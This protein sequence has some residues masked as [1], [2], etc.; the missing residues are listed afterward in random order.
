[1]KK[2]RVL[3]LFFVLAAVAV[4]AT[5]GL[6]AFLASS[7]LGW[8]GWVVDAFVGIGV[9][10][11]SVGCFSRNSP[12]FG[13]VLSGRRVEDPVLAL[14]F[15]DGPSPDTTP[16]I[17]DA[18]RAAG[19][20]ATFFVLGK[21]ATQHPELLARIVSEGHEVASH[22]WAHELLIF[23]RPSTFRRELERTA[24]LLVSHGV[25]QPRYFRAP[26]G[27]RGPLSSR[28][29]SRAG[30]QIVGWSAGVFDTALPG[31][32]VIVERS[33][34]ALHPGA[35]LLL[36]DADGNGNVTRS[37]TADALPAI[38]EAVHARGLRT[39]TVSE[40]ATIAPPRGLPW[41]RILMS[42]SVLLVLGFIVARIQ[43]IDWA[44]SVRVFAGLSPGL[45]TAA[46]LA[47]L[48]SIALKATVWQAALETLP[49]RPRIRYRHVVAAT[50]VG[51]L[52]N[53]ILPAR[54][55]EPA[56][57]IVLRRRI[58]RDSGEQVPFA[59]I[60]GTIIAESFVLG[61][62]LVALLVVM[63]F[64]IANVPSEFQAGVVALLGG[65][66][67][68]LVGVVSLHILG[69]VRDRRPA[70]GVVRDHG[71]WRLL[72]RLDHLVRQ[73]SHGQQ[74]FAHPPQIAL[75]MSA[76][77]GCWFANLIAIWFT[78]LAFGLR[79]HAFAAAVVVLAVSN[80]VGA[81]Q[82]T[83]GN[84][85]VFQ[86]ALVLALAHSFGVDSTLGLSFALG[87]Q[88]IE[89]GLGAALGLLFLAAEGLSFNSLRS[90]ARTAV[91]DASVV[92][93]D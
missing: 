36:H 90:S 77:L 21:H 7:G 78:A 33:V 50:L 22:G 32:E 34:R 55:G 49:T 1:M 59:T 75:S 4:G 63:T 35:I 91:L 71:V 41:S 86:I 85:G 5:A 88:V 42:S 53:S 23:A 20:H 46:V 61:V 65:V 51:F 10:L 37:Q 57:A 54:L 62:T 11:T 45:V 56:R 73:L 64:T 89:S 16:R 9:V 3:A 72:A 83:P 8:L 48:V 19:A 87:L 30:Y 26:H 70:G 74:L 84:V 17:L 25:P 81:V 2:R 58:A 80:V 43:T 12:I 66:A 60:A 14:T 44:A 47:N 38:L 15:D 92:P 13:A 52:M 27:F 28:V 69:R 67:V 82:V 68:L 79:P 93:T 24:A 76:G 31:P 39:V 6:H 29:A 40:L 18:L